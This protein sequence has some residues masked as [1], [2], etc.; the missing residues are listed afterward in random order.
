L[1]RMAIGRLV[2]T[3]KVDDYIKAVREG[4]FSYG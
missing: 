1:L 3:D 4:R 2:G